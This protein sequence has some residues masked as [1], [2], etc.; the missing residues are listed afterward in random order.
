MTRLP[1]DQKTIEDFVR[2]RARVSRGA[3]A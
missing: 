2:A 3:A 1:N